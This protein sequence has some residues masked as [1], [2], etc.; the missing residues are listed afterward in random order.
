MKLMWLTDIHLDFLNLMGLYNFQKSLEDA[1]SDMILIG[2]DI[3]ESN[4]IITYLEHLERLIKVPIY[5]VLGNHDYF[6]G[7][8]ARTR[9]NVAGFS[10]STKYTK[11]LT[12]SGIV[13]LNSHTALIGH[14]GWSDAKFGNFLIHRFN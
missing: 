13:K 12:I 3:A 4:S 6:R 11:W 5:F 10:K 8:I 14:D 2:G 7:S 9:A 1:N